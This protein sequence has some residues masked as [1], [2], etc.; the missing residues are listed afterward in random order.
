MPDDKKLGPLFDGI[1]VPKDKSNLTDLEKK[2]LPVITAPDTVRAGECFEVVVE[3]GKLLQHPNEAGHFIEFIELYA[4]HA[5]LAHLDLIAVRTCPV[6]K[7]CVS[8]EKDFGP[9]RAFARCN[10]HGVWEA[11][12]AIT[13]K[14]GA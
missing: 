3:I 2:H 14:S 9:L 1:N 4:G 10:M 8:L 11:Q 5:Y 13:L 7:V 6:L 12:R